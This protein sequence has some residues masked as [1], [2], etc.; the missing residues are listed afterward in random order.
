MQNVYVADGVRFLLPFIPETDYN[1]LKEFSLPE[2]IVPC[3]PITAPE[4]EPMHTS[5]PEMFEFLQQRPTV[6]VNLG[7]IWDPDA[8]SLEEMLKGLDF[9][10][11]SRPDIQIL[12][13]LK[14][15]DDS[16]L[17]SKKL[18]DQYC[19]SGRLKIVSWLKTSPSLIVDSGNVACFVHHGGANSYFEA[20]R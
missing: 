16:A 18:I 5:D 17:L 10:L 8:H 12:W 4:M 14:V 6:L 20:C 13:K 1:N 9:V 7:S 19:S 3:G 15:K 11:A 2:N